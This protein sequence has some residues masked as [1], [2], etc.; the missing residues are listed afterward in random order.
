MSGIDR[1]DDALGGAVQSFKV[2]L[3]DALNILSSV[4]VGDVDASSVTSSIDSAVGAADLNPEITADAEGV[5]SSI[6]EAISSADATVEPDVDPAPIAEGVTAGIDAAD[7]T[8]TPEV[9]TQGIAD[10]ITQAVDSADA[11][12]VVEADT[13]QAEDAIAGLGDAAGQAGEGLSS[14]ADGGRDVSSAFDAVAP[15]AGLAAGEIGGLTSI[16]GKLPPEAKEAAG[17]VTALAAAGG[18]LFDKALEQQTALERLNRTFGETTAAVQQVDV[19]GLDEDISSLALR[20]GAADEGLQNF[21]ASFGQLGISAGKAA[22]EV[23]NT[24]DQIIALATR[25]SVLNPS[26]GTADEIVGRLSTS[27]ARG[28]RFLGQFGIALNAADINARALAD[29]GKSS[30]AELTVYEKSAAGAALATEQLGSKLGRDINDGAKSDAIQIRSFKTALDEAAEAAGKELVGPIVDDMRELLPVAES[31]THLLGVTLK[32]ALD[33]LGPS[34]KLTGEAANLLVGPLEAL[35]SNED[36]I[37]GL[38]ASF[39]PAAG[40]FDLFSSGSDKA[41][42]LKTSLDGVGA[43]FSDVKTPVDQTTQAMADA[44]VKTEGFSDKLNHVGLSTKDL[45]AAAAQGKAGVDGLRDRLEAAGVTSGKY[46]GDTRDV[47]DATQKLA[48]AL[49]RNAREALNHLQATGQLD[50]ETLRGAEATNKLASGNTDYLRVLQ[51]LAPQVAASIAAQAGDAAA[52]DANAQAQDALNA[53]IRDGGLVSA[54]HVATVQEL[55]KAQLDQLEKTGWL[56][57]AQREE[58][59]LLTITQGGSLDYAEAL[60]LV[61]PALAGLVDAQADVNSGLDTASALYNRA[62]AA[63]KL[64]SDTVNQMLTP[65]LDASNAEVHFYQQVEV[66]TQKLLEGKGAF[67]VHTKAGQDDI[68]AINGLVAAGTEWIDKLIA[69]GAST[70]VVNAKKAETVKQ[71]QVLQG[72]YPGL[73]GLIQGYIDKINGIPI[74]PAQTPQVNVRPAEFALLSL[75]QQIDAVN[76]KFKNA[77][78]ATNFAFQPGEPGF[79]RQAGGPVG[80]FEVGTVHQDE[81]IVVGPRP[82]YVVTRSEALAAVRDQAASGGGFDTEAV[83]SALK[84]VLASQRPL[85]VNQVA[86]DPEATAF[87]V[88]ARL[89]SAATR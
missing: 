33:A 17:A 82:G 48:D 53:A 66:A 7:T 28:G 21:A 71:L 40:L 27:L 13:S 25:A 42:E 9:E 68:L 50:A 67:D 74:I 75:S 62:Q 36:V 35:S 88:A 69:E 81:K 55:A 47:L 79:Q 83:V 39:S 52:K 31:V 89:G 77:P 12:V 65:F 18:I 43:G 11:T 34:L 76:A 86:E 16:A 30:A 26:L 22:P 70:D 45:A 54:R 29:T 37:S 5:T 60:K 59:E 32:V 84:S 38:A 4:S 72:Q 20:T 80:A 51:Q 85:I 3:A 73:S 1:I 15:A 57:T 41:D 58:A 87:A 49:Q 56:T 10:D 24:A 14:A 46:A 6:D 44:L 8:V 19:G 64:Y 61:N 63:A 78:F 2:A 23:A